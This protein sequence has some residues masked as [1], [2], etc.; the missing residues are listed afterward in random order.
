MQSERVKQEE[1]ETGTHMC[2]K[3][4][5]EKYRDKERETDIQTER[6]RERW[7]NAG[8]AYLQEAAIS[9]L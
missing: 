4:M 5:R 6:E 3:R 1:R 9:L 7:S 2:K 8:N